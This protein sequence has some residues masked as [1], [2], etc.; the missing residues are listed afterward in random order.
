[1][2]IIFIFI[3][4]LISI[5]SKA[6][7]LIGTWVRC[8]T[9]DDG[10]DIEHRLIFQKNNVEIEINILIEV[11]NNTIKRCF[12]KKLLTIETFKY[13]SED[14][15]QV[16]ST[17]FSHYLTLNDQKS[18]LNFNRQKLCGKSSWKIGERID[19]TDDKYLQSDLGM[20]GNKTSYDIRIN[21]SE[22][23][24]TDKKSRMIFYNRDRMSSFD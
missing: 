13:Y 7:S 11:D 23:H 21:G 14:N 15:F 24:L 20:R 6:N 9:G 2:K 8:E 19:C 18:I 17:S 3:I 16:L 22:L 10:V 4:L 5:S 12:G 1:M